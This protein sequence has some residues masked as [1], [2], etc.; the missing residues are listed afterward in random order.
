VLAAYGVFDSTTYSRLHDVI[1]M[2]MLDPG[3]HCRHYR[4]RSNG[5]ALVSLRTVG[6][7]TRSMVDKR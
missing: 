3:R 5:S 4:P 1:I 2:V 7:T 6:D